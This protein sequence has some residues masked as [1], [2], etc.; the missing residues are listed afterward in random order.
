V[1]EKVAF[2]LR[3]G[4]A[5]VWIFDPVERT[6][7]VHRP[8]RPSETHRDSGIVRAEPVFAD[9]ELDLAEFWTRAGEYFSLSE[10]S[11]L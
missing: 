8:G 7:D 1:A 2:Y 9:F 5:L 3:A 6:L 4:T 11:D 10:D